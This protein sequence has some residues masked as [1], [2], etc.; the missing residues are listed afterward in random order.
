MTFI[1]G[2]GVVHT[3]ISIDRIDSSLGYDEGNLQLVCRQANI[4]KQQMS[5]QELASWCEDISNYDK[6]KK[7]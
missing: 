3:N 1:V 7:K 5:C 6:R 2:Q 4:M